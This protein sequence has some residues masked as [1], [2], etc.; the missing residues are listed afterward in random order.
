M[1]S[2]LDQAPTSGVTSLLVTRV[3]FTLSLIPSSVI[4]LPLVRTEPSPASIWL[5]LLRSFLFV[6]ISALLSST[7]SNCLR[8]LTLSRTPL[9]LVGW[10][11]SSPRSLLLSVLNDLSILCGAVTKAHIASEASINECKNSLEKGQAPAK[12]SLKSIFPIDFIYEGQR[13]KFTATRSSWDAYTLF[14][15]GSKVVVGVRALSDGGLLVSIDGK[16][17]NVYWK[18]EVGATRLSV[19]SKT[20]LLEI[21]SDP[22]QLRTPSPGKLVKFLVENG[23]HVKA[24]QA[25]AEVEV[26]KMYMPLL[27]QEDGIVQPIKQ[28]GS[29]LE[30]GDILAIL[31]LDDPSKV[32]LAKPFEGQ[33]PEYGPPVSLAPSPSSSSIFWRRLCIT[34]LLALTTRL[35]WAL[36]LRL[37]LRFSETLIFPLVNGTSRRLLC[38]LVSLKSW[39]LSLLLL[40][41]RPSRE[42]LSSPPSSFLRRLKSICLL[43][44]LMP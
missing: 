31:A 33:L 28:P 24:G 34:S 14:I 1:N 23:E 8:L 35:L 11:S 22:T 27:A 26:M 19:D 40:L 44:L 20:C 38:T 18:E 30:A 25:Y 42:S 37:S 29:T 41:R 16:S 7:L 21:E 13:F 4:S 32:K 6:V 3:V 2:T 5:L 10:M 43:P 17:H 15:N 39:T 9:P 36:L 12:D